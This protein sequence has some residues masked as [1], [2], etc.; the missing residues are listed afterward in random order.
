[1]T[2][3]ENSFFTVIYPSIDDI[4]WYTN[5]NTTIRIKYMCAWQLIK[6]FGKQENIWDKDKSP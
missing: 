4:Y 5:P 6:T 2:Y 3:N 1:M